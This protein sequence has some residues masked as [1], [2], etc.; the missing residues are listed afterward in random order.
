MDEA[1]VE[2]AKRVSR[3]LADAVPS[4]QAVV[5]FGS[6]ARGDATESS[7]IDLLVLASDPELVP[8]KLRSSLPPKYRDQRLSLLVYTVEEFM[9]H[10]REGAL[11]IAHV[12]KEG[13]AIHDPRGL[14]TGIL[15]RPYEPKIDITK[16]LKVQLGRLEPYE[17]A[18]R[19]GD[20]YLF[21]LAHL[22]SIG[23]GIVMLRLAEEGVFEFNRERAFDQLSQLKP[24][25]EVEIDQ[26]RQLRPFYALVT[27]QE[28]EPL[29]YSYKSARREV[30]ETVRSLKKLASV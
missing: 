24:D 28:R 15:N 27:K 5:L 14:L 21:C 9:G 20:N 3:I 25:V 1:M 17:H 23:K 29:P 19:F 2:Q 7:D 6:V 18:A 16:E 26:V 22:Y 11:F 30:E 10:Y 8:S 13:R 4:I 12:L